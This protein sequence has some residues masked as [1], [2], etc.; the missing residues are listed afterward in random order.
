[1]VWLRPR[2]PNRKG[3][4]VPGRISVA[5]SW[6]ACFALV[7]VVGACSVGPS[8]G[9]SSG[10]LQ[11]GVALGSPSATGSTVVPKQ[12]ISVPPPSLAVGGLMPIVLAADESGSTALWTYS[13]SGGWVRT[14]STSGETALGRTPNGFAAAA[15]QTIETR[16]GSNPG[17]IV[18]SVALKSDQATRGMPIV[19]VDV[20][21]AG[22]IAFACSD[23]QKIAFG[24]ARPDGTSLALEP[25]PSDS[26]APEIA[27]LDEEHV[28]V[29]STD[30]FQVSRLAIVDIEAREISVSATLAGVHEFAVSADHSVVVASTES[31]VFVTTPA[32]IARGAAAKRV[33]TLESAGVVWA[34]AS[35]HD[36]SEVLMMTGTEASDGSVSNMRDVGYTVAGGGWSKSLDAAVP[37]GN[38]VAQVS[39]S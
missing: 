8:T 1:M 25:A 16:T 32:D 21:A 15:G 29:M 5:R 4:N 24:V 9:T 23:G 13:T 18:S 30:K 26:F 37:F 35:D 3:R 20:S 6:A 17:A 28:L 11:T 19:G 2:T 31:G 33:L 36:G 7:V 38:V 14:A 39:G 22:R 12:S 27:W 10:T 34:L